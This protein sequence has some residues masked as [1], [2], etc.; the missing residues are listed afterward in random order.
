MTCCLAAKRVIVGPLGREGVEVGMRVGVGAGGAVVV[1]GAGVGGK[2]VGD[3]GGV[4]GRAVLLG[5]GG[6]VTV[7]GR[8]TAWRCRL[9]AARMIT[10]K[11]KGRIKSVFLDI[12]DLWYG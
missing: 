12:V 8:E 5:A 11:I 10:R 6:S 7:G 2:G 4:G 9:Q 1:V 3:G